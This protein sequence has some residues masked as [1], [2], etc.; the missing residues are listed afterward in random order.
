MIIKKRFF[1][2]NAASLYIHAATVTKI[3][4]YGQYYLQFIRLKKNAQ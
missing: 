3:K 2:N 1:V 4:F